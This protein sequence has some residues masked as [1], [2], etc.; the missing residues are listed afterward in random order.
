M[1]KI[2]LIGDILV[3]V[4][5]KTE[6]N[7]LKMRLGG[8]VHAARALWA[9]GVEY[10]V[11]FFSPSYLDVHIRKY[12]QK[13]GC[14]QIFKLGDVKNLPY[15]ILIGRTSYIKADFTIFR[16]KEIGDQQYDF[17]L[18]DNNADID[19]D[20]NSLIRL[21][22][23]SQILVISGNYDL[24]LLIPYI[25]D[26]CKIYSDI[27]NNVKSYE[28]LK[29]ERKFDTLFLSTSSDLFKQYYSSFD[30]FIGHLSA[31]A[32]RIVL[33]EN[34]GGSRAFD[35][36]KQEKY[37]IPSQTKSI[38]HSVGV[39]DVYDAVVMSLS[40]EPFEDALYRSSWIASD[41]A[42]TTFTENFKQNV[43]RTLSISI[44]DLKLLGGCLVP[45]VTL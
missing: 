19:Y 5:L 10:D 34:R 27:A 3:D 13:V 31:Y 37:S 4:T 17:L 8:I 42:S 15:T 32:N 36:L 23:Y 24:S 33:K 41:Y 43:L 9:M 30:D 18:G 25:S 22:G 44:A 2:C 1:S 11:A 20:K 29:L 35:C 7:P 14:Y 21:S 26:S 40:D 6:F 45:W 12:L 16:T 28:D 38:T 39:G